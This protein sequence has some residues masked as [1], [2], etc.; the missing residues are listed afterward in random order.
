MIVSPTKGITS[1]KRT[2]TRGIIYSFLLFAIYIFILCFPQFAFVNQI[3]YKNF[4]LYSDRPIPQ[5]GILLLKTV[6]YKLSK[7]TLYNPDKI[8]RIFICNDLWRFILFTNQN[9][10]VGGINY[11]ELNQNTFIRQADILK[12]R[13]IN[14]LGFPVGGNNTL[15]YYVAHEVTHGVTVQALGRKKYRNLPGW[16]REGYADYIAKGFDPNKEIP[17]FFNNSKE[18]IP[19]K[20]GMYLRYHLLI[21]YLLDYKK[22]S[23]DELFSGK[24]QQEEVENEFKKEKY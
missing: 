12:N 18:M 8:H 14:T 22:V 10:K 15:S 21:W 17:K 11:T 5:A 7:S 3:A 4:E 13:L 23:E 6:E 20:S 24:F 9:Y 16:I 1:W 19:E 2:I